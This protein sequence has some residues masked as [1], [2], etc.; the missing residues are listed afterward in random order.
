[1]SDSGDA[2]QPSQGR[3]ADEAQATPPKT[4]A[5]GP[6]EEEE[7]EE[8]DYVSFDASNFYKSLTEAQ[9]DRYGDYQHGG[10]GPLSVQAIIA[11]VFADQAGTEAALKDK[12]LED[13]TTILARVT[14]IFVG[15]IIEQAVLARRAR[16]ED[17]PLAPDDVI[18]VFN[19]MQR[20]GRIPSMHKR[21]RLF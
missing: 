5:K 14:K 12:V 9:K 8:Q 3:D 21:A 10:F 13:A 16:G 6:E 18:A 11:E 20:E 15:E 2:Q 7:E 4:D 19:R 1:M 17:G